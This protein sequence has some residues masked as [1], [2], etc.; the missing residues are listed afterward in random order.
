MDTAERLV[1]D[2]EKLSKVCVT[3]MNHEVFFDRQQKGEYGQKKK[4]GLKRNLTLQI[5]RR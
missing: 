4:L 3:K 5:K 1:E 2:F